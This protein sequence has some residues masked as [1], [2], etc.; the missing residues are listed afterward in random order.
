[1]DIIHVSNQ[2]FFIDSAID[3]KGCEDIFTLVIKYYSCIAWTALPKPIACQ[4]IV[5][6]IS[7]AN[8]FEGRKDHEVFHLFRFLSLFL[9]E[10][11]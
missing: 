2:Y 6:S 8:F 10:E 5:M 1:M 9:T 4:I 7:Y 11:N 3:T